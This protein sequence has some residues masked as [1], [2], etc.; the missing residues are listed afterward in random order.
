VYEDVPMEKLTI[1]LPPIELARI[2]ILIES[3]TYPSRSEFIR[4]A[5]R[6]TLDNH[7]ALIQSRIKQITAKEDEDIEEGSGI[8][9]LSMTGIW[10]L[11]RKTFEDALSAGKKLRIHVIGMLFLQNDIDSE[12]I[13]KTVETIRVYGVLKARKDVRAAIKKIMKQKFPSV[14]HGTISFG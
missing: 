5:I 2:D 8:R 4:S 14:L 3:G 12:I 10:S 1:N 7:N 6:N 13:K 11:D 9:K